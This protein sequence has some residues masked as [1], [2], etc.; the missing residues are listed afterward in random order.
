[1]KTFFRAAKNPHPRAFALLESMFGVAI[2]AIGVLALGACVNNCMTAER[3][4]AEDQRA[5]L[6]LQNRMSELQSG[7]TE[8]KDSST[9]EMTGMFAGITLKETRTLL[10]AKN[11]KD[12]DLPG[13]MRIDLEADWR[14][15]SRQESKQLFFY[16]L[17]TT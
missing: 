10:K 5:R 14:S 4:N 17:R 8:I 3:V 16:V 15:G 9:E 6:A 13:L 12:Q 11:E 7:A 1:M 2:F